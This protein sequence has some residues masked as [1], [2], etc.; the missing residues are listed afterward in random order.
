MSYMFSRSNSVVHT[1]YN[2]E[3]FLNIPEQWNIKLYLFYSYLYYITINC[4]RFFKKYILKIISASL[5]KMFSILLI[6][7][8]ILWLLSEVNLF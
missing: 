2:R 4:T 3:G 5:A 1:F 7:L 8:Y 6:P